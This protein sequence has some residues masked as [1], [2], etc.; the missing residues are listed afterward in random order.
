[1]FLQNFKKFYIKVVFIK[2][3]IHVF[4]FK[5][6]RQFLLVFLKFWKKKKKK[7]TRE[8]SLL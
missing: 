5:S 2:D 7:K 4:F 1:M 3:N 6:K 8:C